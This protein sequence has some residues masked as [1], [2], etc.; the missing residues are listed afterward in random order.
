MYSVEK[1]ASGRSRRQSANI[2][3]SQLMTLPVRTCIHKM[4]RVCG[5]FVGGDVRVVLV[6]II[7]VGRA[8]RADCNSLAF[9]ALKDLTRYLISWLSAPKREWSVGSTNFRSRQREAESSLGYR[10]S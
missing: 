5:G 4:D 7:R 10:R 2:N 9:K 1:A 6:R 3:V 8:A